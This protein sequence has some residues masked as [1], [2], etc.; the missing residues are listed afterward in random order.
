MIKHFS[1]AAFAALTLSGT[2]EAK[3]VPALSGTYVYTASEYCPA[4]SNGTHQVSGTM[5]FDPVGGKAKMDA[6]VV[7]GN[8]LEILHIA[9]TQTYSNDANFLNLG[10][11]QFHITY[12]AVAGGSATYASFVGLVSDSGTCGYQG[13]LT[14]R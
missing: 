12:G 5:K 1:F 6:Y 4:G 13:T 7:T 11:N 9:T 10:T 8:A 2:A 3:D 14:L